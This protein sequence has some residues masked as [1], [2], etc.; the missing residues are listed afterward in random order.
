M[1]THIAFLILFDRDWLD[2]RLWVRVC[3]PPPSHDSDSRR[4]A[5]LFFSLSLFSLFFYACVY[6][7]VSA[8][9]MWG[10]EKGAGEKKKRN[11]SERDGLALW[12]LFRRDRIV[13][14]NGV[15][16]NFSLLRCAAKDEIINLDYCQYKPVKIQSILIN[17]LQNI[18]R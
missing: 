16:F 3:G 8:Y 12:L 4:C 9:I 7:C 6:V 2:S 14:R 18:L 10:K 13:D 1:R 17:A 5:Y 11:T 15:D